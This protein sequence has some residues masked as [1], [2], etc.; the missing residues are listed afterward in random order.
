MDFIKDGTSLIG[1]IGCGS[2]M[3][4]V[5]REKRVLQISLRIFVSFESFS[6][7]CGV[8]KMIVLCQQIVAILRKK[9]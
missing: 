3:V 7:F 8:I 6:Y 2:I 1:L 5:K 9:R 4:W